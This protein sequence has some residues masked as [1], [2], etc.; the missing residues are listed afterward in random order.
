MSEEPPPVPVQRP[1]TERKAEMTKELRRA[2]GCFYLAVFLGLF[3]CIWVYF[4][5][6]AVRHLTMKNEYVKDLVAVAVGCFALGGAIWNWNW[7]YHLRPAPLFV[8]AFG[9]TGARVFY[10]IIGICMILLGLFT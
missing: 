2:W 8:N 9:R 3:A 7:F 5:I 4:N 6:S 1:A 10:A